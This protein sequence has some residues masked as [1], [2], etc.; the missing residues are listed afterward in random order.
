VSQSLNLGRVLVIDDDPLMLHA[1]ELQLTR[2]NV[3]DVVICESASEGLMKVFDPHQSDFSLVICDLQ[4]PVMDGVEFVRRLADGGYSGGLML[5]SGEDARTLQAAT[6]LAKTYRLN[7][8]GSLSKPV[9]L[10]KLH[11]A[12]LGFEPRL[13]K[14]AI[15]A[16]KAYTAEQLREAIE[17]GQM[18][19]F[20]QPK[21]SVKDGTLFGLEAM[22]RWQH[23]QDGLVSPDRFIGLAEE[24]GLIDQL[25]RAVLVQSIRQIGQ[26]RNQGQVVKVSVNVSMDNLHALDFPE[27]VSSIL[28][29]NEVDP[30]QLVLEITESRLMHNLNKVLDIVTRLRL[31][32]IGLALDDFGTGHSSLAQLRDMPFDELKLDRSFVHDAVGDTVRAAILHGT[33]QM[34]RQLQM[35]WVAEGVEDRAD[36]RYLRQIGGGYAQGYF[37]SKPMLPESLEH[38][39]REWQKRYLVLD[40]EDRLSI[41]RHLT[42]G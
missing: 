17:L 42:S 27:M 3:T 35:D 34:A 9:P 2:L 37:V 19:V 14:G 16:N 13:S 28:L 12:L 18:V 8:L 22:V 11:Q 1:I 25:T 7:F 39:Q 4:M 33:I 10:D 32:R 24:N 29:E 21:V 23:P 6:L 41:T 20:Y 36:W 26:W 38:W 30:R 5:L 31:K 15:P 40:D